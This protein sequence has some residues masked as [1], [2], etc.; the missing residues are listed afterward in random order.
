M[1]TLA[2]GHGEGTTAAAWGARGCGDPPSIPPTPPGHDPAPPGA[3]RVPVPNWGPRCWCPRATP[4]YFFPL[5]KRT[6]QGKKIKNT[7]PERKNPAHF[8]Y[9]L[10]FFNFFFW[11]KSLR[12]SPRLPFPGGSQGTSLGLA[13]LLLL[14]LGGTRGATPDCTPRYWGAPHPAQLPAPLFGVL[15]AAPTP[16]APNFDPARPALLL[17]L[18][19]LVPC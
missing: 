19:L 12:F 2:S 1:P 15:G 6:G 4:L 9:F 13:E 16:C 14:R 3:R 10:I 5:G 11:G 17:L 18:L 8:F 7:K